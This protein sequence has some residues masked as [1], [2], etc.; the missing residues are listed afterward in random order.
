MSKVIQFPNNNLDIVDYGKRIKSFVFGMHSHKMIYEDG[1]WREQWFIAFKHKNTGVVLELT[2]YSKYLRYLGKKKSV[3]F[4]RPDTIRARGYCICSFLN[5]VLIGK[6]EEFK[7]T[8][9]KDITIDHGNRFL[10]SYADGEASKNKRRKPQ[11]TVKRVMIEIAKFY[12][13][14]QN[15]YGKGAKNIYGIR[16]IEHVDYVDRETGKKG[17]Y[18]I[19]PFVVHVSDITKEKIFRDIPNKALFILIHLSKKVYPEMTLALCLQ[20]F[21]G[22]RIGEMCNVRQEI[23]PI[24]G[25]GVTYQ[26][27]GGT[28]AR[29]KMNLLNKYPYEK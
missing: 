29:F 3:G 20:A 7:L 6:F 25:G 11:D 2:P 16:M 23:C 21:A 24:D 22:L 19:T 15:V 27:I 18:I 10:Q 13:W 12:I 28:L 26:K 5:Y 1:T 14:L 8:N 9:L 4:R 17:S